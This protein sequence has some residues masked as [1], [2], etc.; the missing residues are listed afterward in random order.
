PMKKMLTKQLEQISKLIGD[1]EG[2]EADIERL[3]ELSQSLELLSH[4]IKTAHLD[5]FTDDREF[6]DHGILQDAVFYFNSQYQ[7][8]RI[9]GAFDKIVDTSAHVTLPE[10]G[11]LFSSEGFKIFRQKTERLLMS[12]EPQSFITEI[13]SKFGLT[14]P[15]YFLLEKITLGESLEAVSAGMIFSSQTPSELESYR[16]ILIENIPGIDVYLFDPSF[17]Y[18]LAGGQEKERRGLANSDFIGKTLFE[19]YDEKTTKRLFPFYRNALDGN[20]SEGEVRIKGRVYFIHSTPVF[21]LA[22]QVVGGALILQDVT[23]EK[24]VE[25]SLL[26]A[27]KEAEESN[28]AKSIFMANMSHEIRTPLNA[29]IGFS[30]LLLKTVLTEEQEKYCRLISKSSEHL[31]S[32]VNE[33]LFLFKY[34]MGKVY[35]EKIPLNV[36]ELIKNVHESLNLKAQEKNLLFDVRADKNVPDVV[37]GDPFRVKQILINLAGNAI[38]FTDEGKVS[39]RVTKEK[40]TRKSMFL[41]FDVSDTGIGIPK[42]DLDIIFDE[43]AQSRQK[44]PDSRKGVGLGLTIVRKLVELLNG[45]IY[46]ES[47]P[48]KGSRFTV[49][50]PFGRPDPMKKEIPD[51]NYELK[52][53]LLK[54]KRI[55]YAD[56][57]KNNILLGESILKS[58]Q[59]DYEIAH[60]GG[61]AMKFLEKERFDVVLLD[62]RMPVMMGTEVVENVRKKKENPNADTR[63]IAVTANI[64]ESEIQAY[65]KSGFDGYV[66]KPF[67]E[68]YL[69][70]K[71]CNLL[72]MNDHAADRPDDFLENNLQKD[73]NIFDTSMLMKT[74]GGN[75][76]FFNKM[77][78]TFINN[79]SETA[80]SFR[81]FS[82]KKKW[83]EI[84][85]QA[86]KAIPSFTYFGL[87]H[88][89]KKLA[90]IENLAL[91]E[92][93]YSEIG[94]LALATSAEIENVI[95]LAQKSKLK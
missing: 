12:G 40:L 32:V 6:P 61:E 51:K 50:L 73:E 71:I 86:H 37:I 29:I 42:Q 11:S 47:A 35:I 3:T 69:Y 54:G 15:V 67:G 7:I 94:K 93:S 43:F 46:V 88:L 18:V 23:A 59:S 5:G 95:G 2:A 91:R 74:T 66:L 17:R 14:L 57:D 75:T 26:K 9:A 28:N 44:N 92:K 56:D 39:V 60:D 78:D 45:R 80:S 65:F 20:E 53:N 34:G 76:D 68:E 27:K 87:K 84:G 33:I 81:T 58:W 36:D 79:A 25:K 21:G 52:H 41:R 48:G 82:E 55:L 30:D 70:N 38:K 64:M 62:I 85:E 49:V 77:L 89:V 72:K 24:E 13:K 10:V 1:L 16:E 83:A 31:L 4:Q 8:F 63:I 90:Q 22:R 19:V